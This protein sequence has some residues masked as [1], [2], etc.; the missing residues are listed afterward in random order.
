LKTSLILVV[1]RS[2]PKMRELILQLLLQIAFDA[3]DECEERGRHKLAEAL[4]KFY[5]AKTD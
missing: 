1:E 4:R 2:K 5:S 3:F